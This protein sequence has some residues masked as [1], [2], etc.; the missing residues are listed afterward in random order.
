A[1]QSTSRGAAR[2]VSSPSRLGLSSRRRRP[3]RA[4]PVEAAQLPRDLVEPGAGQGG[5]LAADRPRVE[6][7]QAVEADLALAP[8][9][10][11]RAGADV[12]PVAAVAGL[13]GAV[14]VAVLRRHLEG[15]E[16]GALAGQDEDRAVLA[17]GRVVLVGHPRPHD[18]TRVRL[19]VRLGAVLEGGQAQRR[20]VVLAR[21]PGED[22]VVRRGAL[23]GVAPA[24]GRD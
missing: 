2:A 20:D 10:V 15:D 21:A 1:R 16:P 8:L 7:E 4:S 23:G 6:P 18:L 5:A 13:A 22:L 9:G 3:L 14:G 24:R 17:L 11:P 12:E 19:V